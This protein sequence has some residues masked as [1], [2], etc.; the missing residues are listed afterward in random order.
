MSAPLPEFPPDV[1]FDVAGR[2]ILRHQLTLLLSALP[3]LR[4]NDPEAVHDLRVATRRLRASLAVFAKLF[5]PDPVREAERQVARLTTGFGAVRD[6]DVQIDAL[7]TYCANLPKEQQY[8]VQRTIARLVRRRT[9]ERKSLKK[10]L[11]EL[12]KGKLEKRLKRLLEAE[13][14]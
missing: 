7:R 13:G 2:A 8:G 3:G 1:P 6:L 9:R 12:E 4:D 11:D 10:L 5:P 14:A